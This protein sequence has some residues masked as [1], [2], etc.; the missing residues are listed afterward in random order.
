MVVNTK[1]LSIDFMISV[2]VFL[3]FMGIK[4]LYYKITMRGPN[5]SLGV[6][7]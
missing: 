4:D 1:K 3:T 7:G 2:T 6:H 5:Q